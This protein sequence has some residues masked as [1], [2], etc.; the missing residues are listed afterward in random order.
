[1]LPRRPNAQM[2]SSDTSRTPYR[3]QISRRR[4]KYPSGGTKHPPEFCT[5]STNT[6]ATVSGPARKMACSMS[7]A[8]ASV[9][10]SQ[11]AHSWQR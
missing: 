1:M 10:A 9:Q 5:G 4:A 11:P 3:S 6:A 7:S 8:Q 2:T